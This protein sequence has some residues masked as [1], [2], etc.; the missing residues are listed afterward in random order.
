MHDNLFQLMK[1]LWQ[2]LRK[3][4]DCMSKDWKV[5]NFLMKVEVWYLSLKPS[6]NIAKNQVD[7]AQNEKNNKIK[8]HYCGRPRHMK[9]NCYK[10]KNEGSE[11]EKEDSRKP[12]KAFM[13]V[14]EK[15]PDYWLIDSRHGAS[16]HVSSKLNWCFS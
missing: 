13:S 11:K 1:E 2:V 5:W 4:Y 16:R 7:S 8:C 9:R 10:F 12:E 6:K 3:D 15:R 14:A